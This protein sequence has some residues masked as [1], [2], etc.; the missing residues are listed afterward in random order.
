MAAREFMQRIRIDRP[1]G[2]DRLQ[3]ETAPDLQAGEGQLRIAVSACGVNFADCAVRMGLYESAKRYVG[4]PITPGFEVAGVVDQLGPGLGDWQP[5]QR[6]MA[7]TRFGGYATQLVCKPEFVRPIPLDWTDAQAAAWPVAFLTAWYGLYH[8]GQAQAGDTVL[9]HSA[10]G[11][12]GQ[13]LVQLAR[14]RGCKTFG[15]VS[16]AHK[17]DQVRKLG[18]D[19]VVDRAATDWRAAARAFAPAGYAVALDA[20]GVDTLADSYDLT[21]SAGRLIVYGFATMLRR[22]GSG[23]PDWLKL[24]WS[25]LRTP[26]FNPLELTTTNRSV[27]AFNLSFLFDRTDILYKAFGELWPLVLSGQLQPLATSPFALAEAA[28]AHGQLEGGRTMGKLVLMAGP[29]VTQG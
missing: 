28:Q 5:G 4:W 8:L 6:V 9:I 13:A 3:L 26:R 11:G 29:V 20:N 25:W 19:E 12:V 17:L 7:M 16:G 1:G 21:G 2:Y 27:L 23:K 22:G 18:C 24:A 10:A 15:V 14:V